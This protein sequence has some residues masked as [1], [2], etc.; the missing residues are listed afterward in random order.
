MLL[1]R[2]KTEDIRI[3]LQY[4]TAVVYDYYIPGTTLKYGCNSGVELEWKKK[5]IRIQEKTESQKKQKQ[6]RKPTQDE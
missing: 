6:K 5:E 4:V 3:R 2:H 1:F